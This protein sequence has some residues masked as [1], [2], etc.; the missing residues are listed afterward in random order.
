[1]IFVWCEIRSTILNTLS[2]L[3]Y[4]MLSINSCILIINSQPSIYF[5]YFRH[6]YRINL[7]A[8]FFV[9]KSNGIHSLEAVLMAIC[10]WFFEKP[11]S[12]EPQR[13]I[14]VTDFTGGLLFQPHLC[15]KNWVCHL[16]RWLKSSEENCY[17]KAT[18]VQLQ[19]N[20]HF[21]C[22]HVNIVIQFKF[23][24][25]LSRNLMSVHEQPSKRPFPNT[26]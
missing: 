17:L 8:Y 19:R 7:N 25:H 22:H 2:I 13:C 10:L 1:M 20:M 23:F 5:V 21:H 9:W 6:F 24:K 26:F 12:N 18:H 11:H 4:F 16:K 3:K 14:F 15:K